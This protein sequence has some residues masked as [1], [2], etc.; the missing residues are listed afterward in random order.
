MWNDKRTLVRIDSHKFLLLLVS[1]DTLFITLHFFH[2]LYFFL[3]SPFL[4]EL[5]HPL[6][7]RA[8]LLAKDLGVAESFQYVKEFWIV[9]ILFR[10]SIRK[11]HAAYLSWSFLFVY[12][13]LDDMFM[14][15]ERLGT[16]V[17]NYLG[18]SPML[19]LR[20][21]DFG[22]LTVSSFF[23]LIFLV[24]LGITYSRSS[25]E[26]RRVLRRLIMMVIGLAVF[27]VVLD[28]LAIMFGA[29]LVSKVLVVCEDSGEMLIMSIIC[30]YVFM[31][32][33]KERSNDVL[34]SS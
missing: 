25:D 11:F 34:D 15:H 27:G 13:L 2:K 7:S 22:E 17:A 26:L 31:L 20:A 21:Q 14:I 1:A 3:E 24:L 19:H 32:C 6:S 10:L 29:G 9:L 16:E 5:F 30:W 23:G 12:L 18:Y 33:R 4:K 8:F 28:M